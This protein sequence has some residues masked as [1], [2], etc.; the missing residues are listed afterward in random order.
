MCF[1]N[2]PTHG[3]L[4]F[5]SVLVA[6]T[7][8]AQAPALESLSLRA[9]EALLVQKNRELQ[10]ARRALEGAEADVITAGARPNPTLSFSQ[11]N[12]SRHPSGGNLFNKSF[13]TVVGISQLF[14]RG[15]KEIGRA[16]V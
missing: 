9:A 14:E 5:L 8:C 1:F 11:T 16:H 10:A 7:A 3:L 4:M 6:G 13:D 2:I 15:N 12:I